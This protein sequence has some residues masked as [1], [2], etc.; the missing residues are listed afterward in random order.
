[1]AMDI[2][3]NRDTQKVEIRFNGMVITR[4]LW[5]DEEEREYFNVPNLLNDPT[6][7]SNQFFNHR[8]KDAVDTI[9]NGDGDFIS[10]RKS[11][12]FEKVIRYLDREYGEKVRAL[13]LEGWKNAK[14]AYVILVNGFYI[15]NKGTIDNI[16]PHKFETQEE[17]KEYIY[18]IHLKMDAVLQEYLLLPEAKRNFFFENLFSKG[19]YTFAEYE[20]YHYL[21]E[22]EF[23]DFAKF[24]FKIAQITY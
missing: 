9:R 2:T 24:P 5:K 17:A 12:G 18:G 7:I 14:F 22:K 6:K 23:T 3:I 11:F 1:M 15:D 13:F 19:D 21:I 16:N 20:Y 10:Q 8:I 4:V